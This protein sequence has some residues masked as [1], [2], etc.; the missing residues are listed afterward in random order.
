[1]RFHCSLWCLGVSQTRCRASG[2]NS[3]VVI[4]DL[5]SFKSGGHHQTGLALFLLHWQTFHPIHPTA[6]SHLTLPIPDLYRCG[7]FFL[8]RLPSACFIQQLI[9]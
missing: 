6:I 7:H 1:M 5:L 9:D 3:R 8:N 2:R 4:T